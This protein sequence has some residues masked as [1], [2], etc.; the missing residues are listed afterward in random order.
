MCLMQ[1]LILFADIESENRVKAGRLTRKDRLADRVA[2]LA[3]NIQMMM[4]ALTFG[5]INM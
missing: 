4:T 3:A 2:R 5:K 1:D